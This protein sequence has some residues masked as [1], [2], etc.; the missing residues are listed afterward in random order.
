MRN[1]ARLPRDIAT[2]GPDGKV[3]VAC[4]DHERMPARP[5]ARFKGDEVL[6]TEIVDDL[7]RHDA[8]LGRSADREGA[9]A[10][11]GRQ[12]SQ[13]AGQSRTRGRWGGNL[14]RRVV[15]RRDDTED[16]DGDVDGARNRRDLAG[17]H[18]A[19]VVVAISEHDDGAAPALA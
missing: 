12:V 13:R 10:G 7:P 1:R 15:N 5:A 18:A 11:P 14:R 2:P 6:M 3:L 17:R 9:P 16:V 8:A 4:A 19:G